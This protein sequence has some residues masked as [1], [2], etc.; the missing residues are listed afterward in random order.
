MNNKT[1]KGKYLWVFEEVQLL[2]S[3]HSSEP[4]EDFTSLYL[5]DPD[6]VKHIETRIDTIVPPVFACLSSRGYRLLGDVRKEKA[7]KIHA[8]RRMTAAF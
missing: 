8:T 3:T 6:A 7:W 1:R 4:F 5:E 2:N